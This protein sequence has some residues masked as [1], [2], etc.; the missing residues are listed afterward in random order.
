MFQPPE[1]VASIAQYSSSLQ[2]LLTLCNENEP[3]RVADQENNNCKVIPSRSR[4][5]NPR[6]NGVSELSS[7]STTR[8]QRTN[9]NIFGPLLRTTCY[10]YCHLTKYCMNI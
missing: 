9:A 4:N 3:V 6:I 1:K 2:N 5:D 7:N 8:Q 10:E